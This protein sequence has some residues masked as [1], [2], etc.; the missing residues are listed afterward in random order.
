MGVLH[1]FINHPWA[2]A[3]KAWGLHTASNAPPLRDGATAAIR[4][5]N[6]AQARKRHGPL[7]VSILNADNDLVHG[8]N[9]VHGGSMVALTMKLCIAFERHGV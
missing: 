1:S 8:G 3:L 6:T 4:P 5:R 9:M 7:I 2:E